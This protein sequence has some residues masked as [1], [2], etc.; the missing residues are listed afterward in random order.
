[1]NQTVLV[2]FDGVLFNNRRVANMVRERSVNF[3]SRNLNISLSEASRVNSAWYPIQ[4]HTALVI[5]HVNTVT[6]VRKYNQEVFDE[7]LLY[8]IASCVDERDHRRMDRIVSKTQTKKH[9]LCTNAPLSYCEQVMHDLGYTLADV[10][11]MSHAFTSDDGTVK[12]QDAY[13]TKIENELPG[14]R[15]RLLLDDSAVHV[16]TAGVR[17]GWDATLIQ[18]EEQLYQ[19]LF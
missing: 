12:P 19:Y 17:P 10:F 13:W 8:R 14:H 15:K 2:D 18:T 6:L 9:H 16:L 3:L 1:M 11:D 4:G 7:D 5:R